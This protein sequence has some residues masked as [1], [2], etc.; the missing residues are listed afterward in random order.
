[1]HCHASSRR[2][3]SES[4]FLCPVTENLGRNDELNPVGIRDDS[5][6]NVLAGFWLQC[7]ILLSRFD[8]K[9][10]TTQL[11]NAL[12]NFPTRF[13]R[14]ARPPF[15]LHHRQLRMLRKRARL[16]VQ[17]ILKLLAKL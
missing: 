16:P 8:P 17:M 1:M 14:H 6:D 7:P 12:R 2:R 15:H 11:C 3:E 13:L 5:S 10:F 9:F 4:F